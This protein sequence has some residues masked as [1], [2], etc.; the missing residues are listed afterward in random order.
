MDKSLYLAALPHRTGILRM[1]RKIFT[2]LIA[3]MCLLGF[4]RANAT[5]IVGGELNYKY[6]GSN[7]YEVLLTIYRDCWYGVVGFDNP[8]AVGIFDANNV[9][10]DTLMIAY[11]DTLYIPPV[12]DLQCVLPPIDICYSTTT[13]RRIVTLPPRPGGYQLSYQRCCRNNSIKNIIRPDTTGATYYATIPSPSVVQTNSNP[14]FKKLPPSFA[15]AGM[16]FVFD[17]SA[18]D[19][20]GDSLAYE[21]CEPM[22][23]ARFVGDYNCV[24]QPCG[25]RPQPPFNPPY[26]PVKW[27]PPYSMANV[28]GGTPLSIDPKTGLLTAVPSTIGQF[29][30]GVCVKEYRKGVYVGKTIRDYQLNVEACQKS[31]RALM[32]PIAKCGTNT[33]VPMT[34]QSTNATRYQWDFGDPTTLTDTSTRVNPVYQ[35]PDTGV[36]TVKLIAYS[37]D[38]SCNDTAYIKVTVLPPFESSVSYTKSPCSYKASFTSNATGN[39]TGPAVK[40]FWSFGDNYNSGAKNPSHTYGTPGPFQ[41]TLVT[42]SSRGCRDT[43]TI[44]V[45]FIPLPNANA[46]PDAIICKGENF[47][48]GNTNDPTYT[49]QWS[50]AQYLSETDKPFVKAAPAADTHF[51]LQVTDTNGCK[52]KDSTLIA[53]A[54]SKMSKADTI[55]LCVGTSVFIN[56]GGSASHTYRWTPADYLND[57]TLVNPKSV[58]SDGITYTA[59][60]SLVS[61]NLTTCN[62]LKTVTLKVSKDTVSADAGTDTTV[63]AGIVLNA[64]Y[65]GNGIQSIIWTSDRL[66]KDTLQTN[67]LTLPVNL[68]PGS[69]KVYY[70]HAANTYCSDTDSVTVLLRPA[71]VSINPVSPVCVGNSITLQAVNMNAYDTLIY[72]WKPVASIVS[73]A[74]ASSAVVSPTTN[75]LYTVSV[76]NQFG[77]LD[78]ASQNVIALVPPNVTAWAGS[79]TIYAGDPVQLFS[80]GTTGVTYQ[81]MPNK[82]LTASGVQ[83]TGASPQ[84]T[85]TYTIAV[86]DANGCS[87]TARVQVFVKPYPPCG[88][89][90]IYVPNAFSPNNDNRNDR[91]FVRGNKIT[92]LYFVLYNRWGEKVFETT[93]QSE[94]WDGT[95][96]GIPAEPAVFVYYL[97]VRCDDGNEYFNKGNVT[98]LR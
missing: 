94:G 89:P 2:V 33:I 35:Y 78:S 66:L 40:W 90:D 80:S 86:T 42:T 7:R 17:H 27:K 45:S 57:S 30:Y 93:S 20:D 29:V 25:V 92:E 52:A 85:T 98:L 51:L 34:N 77:C 54:F 56:P 61:S 83:N 24:P 38:P 73:G 41:A 16:P 84:T 49:Y 12:I 10:L 76:Q 87:D 19:D 97:R 8:A 95:Y 69:P 60:V 13:Y 96:K 37:S 48:I 14:R 75:T 43:A 23:G 9:L 53:I 67:S 63:C 15:C 6:L 11:H 5:H 47:T 31:T 44:P 79:D 46:G 74:N 21:L 4:H 26:K 65:Q 82:G 28:F 68:L 91:L 18:T 81:W 50:P 62:T 3:W 59:F 32:D 22:V 70:F 72:S 36:Y 64:T 71:G 88:E 39:A 58:P 55:P 1:Q